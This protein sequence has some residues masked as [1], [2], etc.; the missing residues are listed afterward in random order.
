MLAIT[1]YVD[2]DDWDAPKALGGKGNSA[3]PEFAA[4]FAQQAGR[5]TCRWRRSDAV[6]PGQRPSTIG[7]Y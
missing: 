7:M 3:L 2:L 6:L 4:K 1:V 5:S